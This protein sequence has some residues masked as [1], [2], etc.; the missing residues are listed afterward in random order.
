[1]SKEALRQSFR[2]AWSKREA[3]RLRG[4]DTDELSNAAH[5]AAGKMLAADADDGRTEVAIRCL[6]VARAAFAAAW[7]ELCA[8][9][10]ENNDAARA[11]GQAI[12]DGF[13]RLERAL[14]YPKGSP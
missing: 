11:A 14:M 4:A 8:A 12:E 13:A 2:R 10:E 5:V 3:A 9:W 1:M 7:P 6:H